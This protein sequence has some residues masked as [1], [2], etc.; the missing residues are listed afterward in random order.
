MGWCS[1]LSFRWGIREG[2]GGGEEEGGGRRR[3]WSF[4]FPHVYSPTHLLTLHPPTPVY[5]P[6]LLKTVSVCQRRWPR[7]VSSRWYRYSHGLAPPRPTLLPT[8]VREIGYISFE[9]GEK[10]EKTWREDNHSLTQHL[11]LHPTRHLTL[12]NQPIRATAG[13]RFSC[14]VHSTQ[15]YTILHCTPHRLSHTLYNRKNL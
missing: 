8:D 11:A 5:P 13:I 7:G 15:Y 4:T 2:G 10:T 1:I 6:L 12:H 9:R 3:S 14:K